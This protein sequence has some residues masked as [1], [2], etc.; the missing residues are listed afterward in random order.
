MGR[1]SLLTAL[2]LLTLPALAQPPAPAP[3]AAPAPPAVPAPE[4]PP[5]APPPPEPPPTTA[6]GAPA[7]DPALQALY[8]RAIAALLAGNLMAAEMTFEELASRTADS[9]AAAQARALAAR[10]RALAMDR[11]LARQ[12]AAPGD[13]P[14]PGRPDQRGRTAFL[15]TTTALGLAAWGWMLPTAL[16]LDP[17]SDDRAFIGLYMVTAASAFVA[18]YFTTR[19]APVTWGQTNLAFYGGTRGLEW[20]VLAASIVMGDL[21]GDR[22]PAASMLLGSIAGLVGGYAWAG[23][24]DMSPGEARLVA[25]GGDAGLFFGF[26]LGHVLGLDEQNRSFDERDSDRQARKMATMGLLGGAAGVA[27]GYLFGRDRGLTWGDGEVMRMSAVVG[28]WTGLTV[29]VLGDLDSRPGVGLAMAGSAGALVGAAALV[30]DTRFTFAQ[31]LLVD[32]STVAGGL[33]AAGIT[34]L[35]SES[36]SPKP[37]FVAGTLGASAGFALS[38]FAFHDHAEGRA[39]TWLRR[40][41]GTTRVGLVPQFGRRGERGLALGGLF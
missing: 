8:D 11:A 1:L 25:L 2:C 31:A 30:R 38:Y 16:D 4:P 29:A 26:G 36:D 23:A 5:P 17:G 21:D 40:H 35:V 22:A 34:F 13:E 19:S 41:M 3:E 24:A 7:A 39:A 14:S 10:V 12:R 37:Y 9:G 6:P 27:G 33:G 20:G 32:L 15:A 18:P 28:A